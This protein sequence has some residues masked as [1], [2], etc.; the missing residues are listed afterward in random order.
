MLCKK[1]GNELSNEAKYCASCGASCSIVEKKKGIRYLVVCIVSFICLI[2]G[3]IFF[4]TNMSTKEDAILKSKEIQS[5]EG[6]DRKEYDEKGNLI[7]WSFDSNGKKFNYEIKWEYSDNK[8]IGYCE[9]KIVFKNKYDE[10]SNLVESI[11]YNFESGEK[12]EEI[13][14]KYLG[15]NVIEKVTLYYKEKECYREHIERYNEYGDII[16]QEY[17]TEY[18]NDIY[19]YVYEYDHHGKKVNGECELTIRSWYDGEVV[20]TQEFIKYEFDLKGNILNIN[21]FDE[22]NIKRLSEQ[23]EYDENGNLRM[24]YCYNSDV[25]QDTCK[26]EYDQ[27]G[28][29]I[30][31]V[32]SFGQNIFYEY[33]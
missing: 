33:Y 6:I 31:Q 8:E 14:I 5:T 7:L 29:L 24:Y 3:G 32:W 12:K 11:E 15:E 17:D 19:E 18:S 22:N 25:L 2:V 21:T 23:Y 9:S 4:I 30:A 26:F 28:N 10:Q 16:Y 27:D 1:C 13:F 20:E